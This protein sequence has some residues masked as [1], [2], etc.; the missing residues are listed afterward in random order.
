MKRKVLLAIVSICL[1]IGGCSSENNLLH[2]AQSWK[3]VTDKLGSSFSPSEMKIKD[4]AITVDF[5]LKK[6]E[7]N[8]IVFIELVCAL[9]YNL[10]EYSSMKIAYKCETPLL[11]K[12]SQKDFGKDGNESYSHYQYKVP[13]AENYSELTLNFK[14]F[15]QPS[16]TPEYSKDIPLKLENVYDIYLTPDVSS[17]V[18]G[19]AEL[20]VKS[21][22]L[23]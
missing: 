7:G 9:D 16:W 11:I 2:T 13:A 10:K 23:N 8:E 1:F 18:G 15:V 12:L 3:A 19:S 6:K 17:D 14:D 5:T 22:I 21:I 20:S 4:D